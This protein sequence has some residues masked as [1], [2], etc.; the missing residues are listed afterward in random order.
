M[1]KRSVLKTQRRIERRTQH[2]KIYRT[3]VKNLFRK[4]KTNVTKGEIIVAQEILRLLFSLLDKG[5]KKGVWHK[6]TAARKKSRASLLLNQFQSPL[7]T[8]G[9]NSGG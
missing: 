6:N 3:R 7:T 2:H 5:V 9:T 1:R 8:N 4:F